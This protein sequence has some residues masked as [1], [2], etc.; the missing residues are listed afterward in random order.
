MSSEP[1]ASYFMKND[2]EA[3]WVSLKKAFTEDNKTIYLLDTSNLAT[4]SEKDEISGFYILFRATNKI[5]SYK[6]QNISLYKNSIMTNYY[7]L[8][9]LVFGLVDTAK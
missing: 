4:L 7:F 3:V 6:L 9:K 8:K 2:K 1:W 5:E